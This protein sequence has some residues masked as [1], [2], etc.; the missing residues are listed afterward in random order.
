MLTEGRVRMCA[1]SV[2]ENLLKPKGQI[3]LPFQNYWSV[4]L[5]SLALLLW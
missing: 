1:G 2:Q 3:D 5:V 4:I